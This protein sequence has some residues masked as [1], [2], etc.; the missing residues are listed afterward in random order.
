M[1]RFDLSDA[2]WAIIAPLL[3]NKPRGVARTDDRRVLN[4]IFYILRTGSPWRDLPERY[5]PYTTVYNRFNR[6]AK[7]GVWIN[8]FNA[9]A[10]QSPES[11]A[12]IDSSIIRAHQHAAG[13]KKGGPDHAIGLSRGGLSTK[14]HAVV[15]EAGLPIRLALSPGQASDKATG[16]ALIASLRQAR[17]VVADR[18]YDARALIEQIEAAGAEAHIPTQRDR[19]VQRSVA[20]DIYRQRNLVERYFNKLKHF[21]RCATRFDKLA[22]NF[23]AAIAL[24][25][26]RLWTRVYEST[27]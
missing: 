27:T 5:G 24:A 16:A 4:G 9:L 7:A 8:V 1:A 12:F 11:M 14:I 13:R 23:L 26:T 22:R 15:D 3:P 2:E 21:R 25:S 17:H 10:Q 19:K 18:G 6:W 20:R